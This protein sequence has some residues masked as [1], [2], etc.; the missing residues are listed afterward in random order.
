MKSTG[1]FRNPKVE[2][3]TSEPTKDK[4]TL[5]ACD[6][7]SGS[8]YLSKEAINWKTASELGINVPACSPFSPSLYSAKVTFSKEYQEALA[9]EIKKETYK[10]ID[11]LDD[12]IEMRMKEVT[13][14]LTEKIVFLQME[15]ESLRKSNF[16]S[17]TGL[18]FIN[19]AWTGSIVGTITSSPVDWSEV[20]KNPN[21]F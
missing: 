18:G 14:K 7:H 16:K 20:V 3:K 21:N 4:L 1:K 13:E 12:F 8:L 17:Y 11:N 6:G 19:E 9:V 5:D 15:V 2:V 10:I